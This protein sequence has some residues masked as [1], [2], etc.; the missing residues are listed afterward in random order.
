MNNTH[1]VTL[2]NRFVAGSCTEEEKEELMLVL[3]SNKHD[4]LLKDYIDVSWQKSGLPH[5]LTNIKSE[6]ILSAILSRQQTAE[7]PSVHAFRKNK[8]YMAAAGILLVVL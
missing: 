6:S 5:Q 2:L 7:I 3:K 1:I 8:W 4:E